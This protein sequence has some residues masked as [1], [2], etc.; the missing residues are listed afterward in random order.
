MNFSNV[1][2]LRPQVLQTF[3][4]VKLLMTM[5]TP[6]LTS[7]DVQSAKSFWDFPFISIRLDIDNFCP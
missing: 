3:N 7:G 6:M 5:Q 2:G 1:K 4:A